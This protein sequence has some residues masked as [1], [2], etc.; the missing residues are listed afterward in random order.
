MAT[1]RQVLVEALQEHT[2][3]LLSG[4]EVTLEPTQDAEGW[5][6][7][8]A[9][10]GFSSG[11]IQG[12][13]GIACTEQV[14][15]ASNPSAGMMELTHSMLSDWLGELANQLL[16][17]IKRE[18]LNYDV[19]ILLATPVVLRGIKLQIEN[20]GNSSGQVGFTSSHG[21]IWVCFDMKHEQG[22]TLSYNPPEEDEAAL[23]DGMSL[24]F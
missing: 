16:G 24:F 22:L 8:I 17:R 11:M 7:L 14:L 12:A 20:Q 9:T 3:N 1:P 13:L 23:E 10:I 19:E 4:Y 18:M 6:E 2:V 21:E 5:M 15:R